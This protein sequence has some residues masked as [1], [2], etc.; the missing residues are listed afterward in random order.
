M[1]KMAFAIW[2]A[3]IWIALAIGIYFYGPEVFATVS[4]WWVNLK[5]VIA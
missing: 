5:E 2:W 3:A 1:S 4:E